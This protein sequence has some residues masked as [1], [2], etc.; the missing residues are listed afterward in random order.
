[1][2]NTKFFN[3]VSLIIVSFMMVFT[4]ALLA[5]GGGLTPAETPAFDLASAFS[6][7]ASLAGFIPVV[8]A[9]FK[10][11]LGQNVPPIV[12][13]IFSWVVGIIIT[14]VGWWLK[15]GF[16][17]SLEWYIVL[18]YGFAASLAANGVANTG[19]LEGLLTMFMPKKL[20]K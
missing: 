14:M 7:F 17:A 15:L 9:T 5:Q 4:S 12:T 10:K 16:L 11:T 6:T 13:Q 8:V 1:M 2:K 19:L 3:L 18:A 20:K